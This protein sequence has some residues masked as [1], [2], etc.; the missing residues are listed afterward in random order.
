MILPNGATVAVVDGGRL[1]LFRNKGHEPHVDLVSLPD[2]EVGS[3]H[4]GSGTRHRSSTAN[5]DDGRLK[6][7]DFIAGAAKHLNAE[8]LA[9]RIQ[10]LLVIADPRS[11]GELRK[12]FHGTLTGRLV[13]EIGKDLSGQTDASIQSAIMAA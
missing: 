12:H 2:P 1:R 3:G 6:E 10:Q 4:A 11:L 5:P 9:G 8:V 7:D 13:G